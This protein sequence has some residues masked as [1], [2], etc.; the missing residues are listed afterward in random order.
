MN[1]SVVCDLWLDAGW[2]NKIGSLFVNF[3]TKPQ[4]Q[5]SI[6]NVSSTELFQVT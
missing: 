3:E 5:C 2:P 6:L 4:P 1:F